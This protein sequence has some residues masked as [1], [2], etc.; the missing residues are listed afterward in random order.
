MQQNLLRIS[1]YPPNERPRERLLQLGASALSDT[2]LLA[3]LLGTGVRGQNVVEL[4]RQLLSTFGGLGGLVTAPRSEVL[5][6]PGIGTAKYCQFAAAVELLSRLLRESG[7]RDETLT[8][9]RRCGEYLRAKLRTQP[10]EVFACLFFDAR[11]RVIAYE[12]LFRGTIDGATVHTREVVRRAIVHNASALIVAHNHPSG[13]N[14]PS[15]ADLVVTRRLLD[16]LALIDVRLL[17]HFVIGDGTPY[18]MAERGMV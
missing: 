17:D 15:P 14:E 7:V 1:D 11:M 5:R 3:L 4:S 18:S 8:E 16:A 9:P 6:T 13:T 12:E 2:E 10:H